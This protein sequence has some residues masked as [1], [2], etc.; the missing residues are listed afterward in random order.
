[1][2]HF[3]CNPNGISARLVGAP[4]LRR[5]V[6][7]YTQDATPL[8]LPIRGCLKGVRAMMK[9]DRLWVSSAR[10]PTKFILQQLQSCE[11]RQTSCDRALRETCDDH[12][13]THRSTLDPLWMSIIVPWSQRPA[14]HGDIIIRHFKLRYP[15]AHDNHDAM[16]KAPRTDVLNYMAKLRETP[17]SDDGSTADEDSMPRGSGWTGRGS[18]SLAG[19]GYCVRKHCDGQT[20]AS[21]GRWPVESRRYPEHPKWKKV[22]GHDHRFLEDF[23]NHET[24]RGNGT[25]QGLPFPV[26]AVRSLKSRTISELESLGFL[27]GRHEEDRP[28]LQ[29]DFRFMEQLMRA[30]RDPDRSIGKFAR[31]VKVG[32]W[33]WTSTITCSVKD[34]DE[35]GNWQDR[36]TPM[37]TWKKVT[38]PKGSGDRSIQRLMRSPRRSK[39]P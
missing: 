19:S 24:S 32:P 8:V 2:C 18:P 33:R 16:S 3:K 20:L 1:M 36:R 31:G 11:R 7:G 13:S 38:T 30:A 29:V 9:G 6:L 23:R 12:A 14:C 35:D 37:T 39:K 27:L 17:E 22:A 21:P 4:P 28:D 25:S 15:T 5:S 34:Q 26:D 10:S